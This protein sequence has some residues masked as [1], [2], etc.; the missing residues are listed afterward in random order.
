MCMCVCVRARAFVCVY[1]DGNTAP[2]EVRRFSVC[3]SRLPAPRQERDELRIRFQTAAAA[4]AW[5]PHTTH[6]HPF[7]LTDADFTGTR[8]G[9]EAVLSRVGERLSFL[10]PQLSGLT[11]ARSYVA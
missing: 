11:Y 10:V 5:S 9:A 2:E 1:T 6:T 7:K 3:A 8:R 4:A